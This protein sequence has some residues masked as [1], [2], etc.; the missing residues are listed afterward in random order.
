[1]A[2]KILDEI[3][4]I[5]GGTGVLGKAGVDGVG[6]VYLIR[7]AG[8]LCI[9]DSGGANCEAQLTENLDLIGCSLSDVSLLVNTHAHGDH[10][11]GN[12]FIHGASGCELAV[13]R[14]DAEAMVRDHNSPPPSRCLED[15]DA[16]T[17]GTLRFEV[18]HTP[19]HT[20][21]SICLYGVV[22]DSKVL[23]SGDA[24]G[25]FCRHWGSDYDQFVRSAERLAQLDV[26]IVLGGHDVCRESP[27]AMLRG[28]ADAAKRG[29]FTLIR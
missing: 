15:G 24:W 21:G 3:I 19:G 10:S 12:A 5:G 1:M 23:F 4:V 20:P 6:T 26:D 28:V 18:L 7:D 27:Q 13:H 2:V 8:H 29:I 11:G 14:D 16:V 9:V 22:G 17:V 25:W